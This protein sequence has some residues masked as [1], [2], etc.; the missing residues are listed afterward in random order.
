[1][2]YCAMSTPSPPS[3]RH[4]RVLRILVWVFLGLNVAYVPGF[5]LAGKVGRPLVWIQLLAVAG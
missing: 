3:D 2:A 1:M 5:M 4:A